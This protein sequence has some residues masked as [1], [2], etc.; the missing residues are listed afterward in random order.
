MDRLPKTDGVIRDRLAQGDAISRSAAFNLG[1]R[2]MQDNASY[3]EAGLRPTYRRSDPA[4][5]P[6]DR[7]RTTMPSND[8]THHTVM[9][10][11]SEIS[12]GHVQENS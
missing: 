3:E 2:Q 7:R 6:Y 4:Q 8:Q 5:S 1:G 10:N 11:I 9:Q 12:G